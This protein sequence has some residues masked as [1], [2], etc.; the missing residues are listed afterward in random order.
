MSI[1]KQMNDLINRR[2]AIEMA[3]GQEATNQRHSD[4]CMTAR[5]RLKMLF[6]EDSF[7]EVGAFVTQRTTN[8]NTLAK[9]LPADGVVTGYGSIDGRLV[10]AYSQDATI[11]GGAM[12][13]MHVKKIVTAYEMALKVGAPMV[14][15]LDTAGV[16]LQEGV[17][18]LDALG[19]I[20]TMQ[21]RAKNK[22][23]QLVAVL[24]PCGGGASVI[25]SFSDFLFM[26]T[27]SGSLYVNSPNTF[28][29]RKEDV[30][31]GDGTYHY[32]E[33]GLVDVLCESEESLFNQMRHLIVRVP[34]NVMEEVELGLLSDSINR[35]DTLITQYVSETGVMAKSL[36]ESVVDVQSFIEIKGGSGKAFVT[37][38]ASMNGQT[39]GI[40]VSNT[41]VVPRPDCIALKKVTSLV[42]FCNRFRLPVITLTDIKGYQASEK[43]EQKGLSA[44]IADMTMAFASCCSPKIN[45]VV[46]HAYGSAYVHFNSKH[47]G[48][49]VTLAWPTAEFGAM[50]AKEAVSI[51]YDGEIAEASSPKETIESLEETYYQL[52]GSPIGVASRG[53]VDD[54]IEPASTRKRLIAA[55]EMLYD[56]TWFNQRLD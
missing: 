48:C 35:V 21:C 20:Y 45:V 53:Y 51:I 36:I 24:G 27:K 23:L 31:I 7:V 47:I 34:G 8:Y 54:I 29:D 55:L 6:D 32:E 13:E 4:G 15:I 49:D 9:P 17:D 14:G 1:Q 38:L 5:E 42:E 19:Q 2:N 46:G 3:G 10:Y 37:G 56:K 16:R 50:P 44:A 30:L 28:D 43:E 40:I 11:L 25:T 33:T 12:G 41:S 52:H 22:I 18:A 26:T 39:V